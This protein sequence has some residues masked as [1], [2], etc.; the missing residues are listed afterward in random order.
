MPVP[1]ELP[2]VDP[3]YQLIIPDE[4]LA[5]N[6]TVPDPQREPSVLPVILGVD[7]MLT[8]SP[9]EV[10]EQLPLPTVTE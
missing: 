5:S 3:A 1:K 2:P 4:A 8:T 7:L 10:A 9:A 6:V